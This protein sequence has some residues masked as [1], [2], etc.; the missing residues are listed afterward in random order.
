[1]WAYGV[2]CLRVGLARTASY[3]LYDPGLLRYRFRS[4]SGLW[5]CVLWLM[6]RLV[7]ARSSCQASI[8]RFRLMTL[9]CQSLA[10]EVGSQCFGK[11]SPRD[12]ERQYPS[13]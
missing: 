7:S 1:M 5:K 6:N 3:R 11:N 10:G 8:Q 9:R 2:A 4:T 12:Q 13:S